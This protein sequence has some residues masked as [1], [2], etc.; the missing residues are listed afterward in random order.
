MYGIGVASSKALLRAVLFGNP[1]MVRIGYK[2]S[3]SE[4]NIIDTQIINMN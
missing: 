2:W 1:V 4:G 3:D